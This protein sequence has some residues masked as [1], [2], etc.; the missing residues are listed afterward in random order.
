VRHYLEQGGTLLLMRVG[1]EA[2]GTVEGREFLDALTGAAPA[3][4]AAKPELTVRLARHPWLQHLDPKEDHP[5][6]T[7]R[8]ANPMRVGKGESLIGSSSGDLA[9]LYRLPVGKGHLVYI[10]W[11]ISEYL[12]AGKKPSTPAQERVFEEQVQVVT[13]IVEGFSKRSR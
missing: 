4:K 3:K 5:W 2:F 9:T 6:V 7:S 13:R 10:G 8:L 12:P 11:E 1:A